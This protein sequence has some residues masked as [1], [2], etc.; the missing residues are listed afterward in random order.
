MA[1]GVDRSRLDALVAA[2]LQTAVARIEKD[3]A[4]FPLVFELRPTGVIHNV[5][6]LESAALDGRQTVVDRL[7]DLLRQRAADR[8]IRGAAIAL[9]RPDRP[10]IEIQLR[11]QGEARDYIVPYTIARAGWL[12]QKRQLALHP[13]E[14]R[15]G[16]NQ[17]F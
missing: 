4:F 13:A 9:H 5:A 10:A 15:E 7:I 8:T 14:H 3:G 6:V 12:R 1:A 11:A 2:A 16:A 17:I